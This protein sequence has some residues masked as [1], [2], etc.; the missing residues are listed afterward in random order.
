[1]VLSRTAASRIE[2]FDTIDPPNNI[3]LAEVGNF[4]KNTTSGDM[5]ICEIATIDSQVWRRVFPQ[6]QAD[7]NQLT[8]TSL[9]YIK[10]KPTIPA[11][12][13][14]SDWNQP[15]GASIDYIKNKPSIPPA[16]FQ[17]DWSQGNTSLVDY[18]KNKP[19][20]PTSLPPNG[21]ASGDLTGFYPAPNLQI[22]GVTAGNYA[23]TSITVDA[24]GRITAASSGVL[25]TT[26]PPNGPAGGDL[27]GTYPNPTLITTGVIPGNYIL[28]NLSVDGRGRITAA[29]S[30][31]ASSTF[32]QSSVTRQLN[33]SFQVSSTRPSNVRYSVDV[34]CNFSLS[35]GEAGIVI[36]EMA[37]DESFSENIQEL[38]R[39]ANGYTGSLISGFDITQNS[40]YVLT[41]YVPKA[42]YVRLRTVK[43]TGNPVFNV[44]S[45]QEVLL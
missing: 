33:H 16:Q 32:S 31:S 37:S 23:H 39:A 8:S 25:P 27:F 12:Q 35:A 41:G 34:A 1:M 19:S 28:A 36:L 38:S 2:Y 43:S 21:S 7:W 6:L 20:I 26:L 15:S 45:G 24:K 10:N 30:G 22:S 40:T 9:D 4:Y 3:P 11:S 17:S 5:F 14:Q 18:I 29:S 13:L 42:Y 44:V